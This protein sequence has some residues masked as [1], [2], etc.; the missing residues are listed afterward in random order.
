MDYQKIIETVLSKI[1][2]KGLTVWLVLF[3]LIWFLTP[4][5]IKSFLFE[6]NLPIFPDGSML[7]IC[8]FTFA[9]VL[10]FA[11]K[12]LVRCI[13]SHKQ[14]RAKNKRIEN[15][16][17][18]L[19]A[20]EKEILKQILEGKVA[21]KLNREIKLLKSKGVII[22]KIENSSWGVTA[23]CEINPEYCLPFSNLIQ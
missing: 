23:Y 20:S 7:I 6:Q 8:L 19:T 4:D 5:S 17:N 16:L 18:S 15:V 9:S 3:V 21:F 10:Y 14:S 1:D 12:W 11:V 22:V 2:F 13:N